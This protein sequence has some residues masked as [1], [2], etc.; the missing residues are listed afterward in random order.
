ME[1]GRQEFGFEFSIH[2]VLE[3]LV[4][5]IQESNPRKKIGF[6]TSKKNEQ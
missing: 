6:K 2:F 3:N 5:L 1:N 4:S